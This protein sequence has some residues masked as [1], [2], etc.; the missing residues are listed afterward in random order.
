MK[1]VVSAF[2]IL[3]TAGSMYAQDGGSARMS[4]SAIIN[5]KQGKKKINGSPYMQPMFAAANVENLN[6]KAFMRYNIVNDEFEFITPKNDTLILDKIEDF[7]SIYFSGLNKRYKLSQYTD[8]S[9]KFHYGYLIEMYKKDD[10]TLFKK[11]NIAFVEEKVAKTS[12]ETS[13]PA[14]YNK[15]ENTYFL[16]NKDLG[17]YE[18][19]DGK[20][21]LIKLFPDKKQAI[22][23]FVKENKIAFDEEADMI[24]IIN[25]IA[26]Q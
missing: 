21:A 20:K 25:F 1:K 15:S 3:L 13:M 8:G 2:L 6:L 22:E 24:K 9:N 14:K 7:N 19:P 5:Q 26:R 18:F 10:Y 17:I 23:A 16:K 4:G 12:L 11:E